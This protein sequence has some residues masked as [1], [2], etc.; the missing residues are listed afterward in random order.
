M[1]ALDKVFAAA[2]KYRASDI[3]VVP[4]EPFVLRRFRK[5]LKL[6]SQPLTAES[7]RKYI[8][9]ILSADQVKRLENDLQL[10]FVHEIS[11]LGRFR[12]NA[13]LH[14]RGLSAVFR[15][16]PPEIPTLPDL[17][18][19]DTIKTVLDHHQGM[20]LVTGPAGHGKSTT[21][22]AMVDHLNTTRKH[23]ILTVEDPIEFVHPLKKGVVNQRQVEKETRSYANALRAALREDPDVIVVGELR[24]LETVSLAIS[25]AETGHLVIGTLASASAP[26][27]VE[28]IIDSYPPNEQNQIRAMVS[29]SLRAVITQRLLPRADTD[30][31]ALALE[32]L[33]CTRPVANLIRDQKVFQIPS[34]M[35]TGKNAGMMIMDES[36][37]A[38]VDAG[39]IRASDA[40]QYA[41]NPNLF[42]AHVE[43]EAKQDAAAG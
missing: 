2:V 7:C 25:A 18:M 17:G 21:L 20:I 11:G 38:L 13:M 24:D 6:K 23:H 34:M 31:M 14:Q 19:P 10:D 27:T 39:H 35:Q 26:K 43:R 1:A 36:M 37:L 40:V 9:G 29:E 16:I 33:I 5:F 28:R 3:H 41:A 22:A 8:Y 42:K 32:V 12:G 15:I 30:A 4:G